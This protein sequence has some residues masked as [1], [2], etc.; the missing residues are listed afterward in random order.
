M[1]QKVLFL[2]LF[3]GSLQ[4]M[5]QGYNH[6]WL[7]GSYNF[8]QD[9][10]GRILFD[11]N[12]LSLLN[13]NRKMPFKGTQANISDSN[14][15]LLMS[16]NGIWIANSTGDTMM[17]GSGLNPGG[18]STS[19]PLTPTGHINMVLPFPNDSAKTCFSQTLWGQIF[20]DISGFYNQ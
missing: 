11:V 3:L 19:W 8:P 5:G 20:P 12:S 1:K 14:G 17:N 2:F 9:P 16:S 18:L 6:Q 10:K 7:L 13:E 15:N 4:S